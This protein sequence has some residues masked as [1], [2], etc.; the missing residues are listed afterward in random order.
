[1]A[2]PDPPHV[3]LTLQEGA[4]QALLLEELVGVVAVGLQEITFFIVC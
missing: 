1:M 3:V 4:V 2:L